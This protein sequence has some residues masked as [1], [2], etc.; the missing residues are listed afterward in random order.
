VALLRYLFVTTSMMKPSLQ[1]ALISA[2]S[3]RA[4]N[5]GSS[6]IYLFFD[7]SHVLRSAVDVK[8]PPD[9]FLVKC[10]CLECLNATTCGC[11]DISEIADKDGNRIFAYTRSVRFIIFLLNLLSDWS[12]RAFL[13]LMSLLELK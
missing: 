1:L 8:K 7:I 13:T 12:C 6:T 5:C 10:S 9:D 3:K 11:Q 2:I 4:I